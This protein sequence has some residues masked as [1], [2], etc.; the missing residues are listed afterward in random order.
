MRQKV[1]ELKAGDVL[2]LLLHLGMTARERCLRGD[3]GQITAATG[4]VV[5]EVGISGLEP[6]VLIA[7]SRFNQYIARVVLIGQEA[8]VAFQHGQE[9]V[10]VRMAED[11]VVGATMGGFVDN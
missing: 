10:V 6:L 7:A 2:P 4:A 3:S 9:A 8:A 11:S 5:V 1:G